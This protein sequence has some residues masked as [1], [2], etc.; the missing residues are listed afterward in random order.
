MR[1]RPAATSSFVVLSAGFF[2]GLGC[3]LDA[4]PYDSAGTSG[5][6]ATTTNPPVGG[7]GTGGTI[8]TNHGGGGTDFPGGT[9]GT[10]MSTGGT[11]GTTGG[12][13]GSTGGTGG[14]GGTVVTVYPASCLEAKMGGMN[15]S[16]VI[17]ID[18]DGMGS[19]APFKVYCD[20]QYDGGGWALVYNSVGDAGGK[21]TEFWNI[22]Y[23][24]RFGRFGNPDNLDMKL[25][26]NYYDGELYKH[27]TEYRDD[28]VGLDGVEVHGIMRATTSG[29]NPDSMAFMGPDEVKSMSG[30]SSLSFQLYTYHFASGWSSPDHDADT[31]GTNCASMFGNVTQHYAGCFKYSLGADSDGDFLDGGWGPHIVDAIIEEINGN[32]MAAGEQKLSKEISNPPGQCSRVRRI[33]RFTRWPP[34]P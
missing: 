14:T 5:S 4:S 26:I 7:G 22:P 24:M 23:N 6:A 10:K 11:A 34:V 2:L 3:F 17:E 12:T 1:F 20:Q 31:G 29:I 27:G 13:G 8:T 19:G 16:G 9:G 15:T 18:P 25:S 32:A 21:T 30:P 33:S 28:A